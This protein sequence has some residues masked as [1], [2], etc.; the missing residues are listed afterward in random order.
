MFIFGKLL[1]NSISHAVLDILFVMEDSS[2]QV[3]CQG[4]YNP[5]TMTEMTCTWKTMRS[6]DSSTRERNGQGTTMSEITVEK[7][8]DDETWRR[9]GGTAR[10]TR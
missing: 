7:G 9:Q 10:E 8:E 4:R 6:L 5:C 3:W 1:N 2:K